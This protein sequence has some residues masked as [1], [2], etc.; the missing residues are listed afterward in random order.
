MSN[1]DF[2]NEFADILTN[3][4]L[5]T[6]ATSEEYAAIW[7]KIN[8]IIFPNIPQKLFR[9]RTCNA[10]NIISFQRQTI[11]TC[12]AK[13][14][15]DR[16]DSLVYIDRTNIDNVFQ[17]FVDA[18]GVEA[19]CSSFEDGTTTEVLESILSPAAIMKMNEEL[20]NM[21]Q[22]DRL[23]YLHN[24]LS[25]FRAQ[26]SYRI[27]SYIEYMR[28]DR[29]T[30]I[31][32]FT[33]DIRSLYMWNQYADGYKGYAL[34]Y[35]FRDYYRQG[36]INCPDIQD[37]KKEN[38]NISRLFPIIYSNERYNAT[39]SVLNIMLSE[40]LEQIGNKDIQLP[41]DQLHW[42]KAYLYKD[43]NAYSHEKEWRIITRCPNQLDS[44]Y[45]EISHANCLKAIY[46]GP[47]MEKRYKEFLI[48][49]A[50]GMGIKQYDVTLDEHSTKYE[51]KVCEIEMSSQVIK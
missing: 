38:K 5:P 45:T 13:A 44:D 30:K 33:E 32:C 50:H 21:P 34:E 19:I 11:S 29:L 20:E 2:K 36:C 43:V 16:Y 18:G 9:F 46:F 14:F 47:F 25:N 37:C 49:I 24:N 1:I 22:Q 23:S 12:V 39:G 7:S 26:F 15:K 31:A 17:Q 51:L 6:N 42:Y 41:I 4:Y 28:A 40:I 48:N 3:S 35:D 8:N 10:D 27:S